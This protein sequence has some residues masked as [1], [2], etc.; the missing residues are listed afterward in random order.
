M[1]LATPLCSGRKPCWF[2]FECSSLASLDGFGVS[3]PELHVFSHAQV[4]LM[5]R[6]RT[7]RSDARDTVQKTHDEHEGLGAGFADFG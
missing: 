3:W 1:S 6:V 2:A 4:S 7:C 5:L